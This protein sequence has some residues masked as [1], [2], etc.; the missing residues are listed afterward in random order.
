M[1]IEYSQARQITPQVLGKWEHSIPDPTATYDCMMGCHF[2]RMYV[3]YAWLY[4]SDSDPR[5]RKFL[6]TTKEKNGIH[7]KT[8]PSLEKVGKFEN[9]VYLLRT[10]P[11]TWLIP[12]KNRRFFKVN[13][14]M[15]N[16][17]N[18]DGF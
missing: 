6:K 11:S 7:P 9:Q 16:R 8:F 12:E 2:V 10:V 14:F 4:G 17:K 15:V 3:Q 1:S 13:V 5:T 18:L